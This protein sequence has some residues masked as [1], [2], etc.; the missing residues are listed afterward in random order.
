MQVDN[1]LTIKQ[2]LGVFID[3]KINIEV[4]NMFGVRFGCGPFNER[5]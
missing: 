5:F 1:L 3:K 2:P 4:V